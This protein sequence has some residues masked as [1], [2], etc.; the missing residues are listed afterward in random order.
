MLTPNRK[1]RFVPP[2]EAILNY[3][4]FKGGVNTLFRQTEIRPTELAQA[5]NLLLTGSGVPT[6]R[7][8]SQNYFLAAATGY[9]RGLVPVKSTSNVIELLAISDQGVIAKKNGASYTP[10]TGASWASGYN[11]EGVQLYNK[12]YFTN[13][14][15]ELVRYDF[16]TLVSFTTIATPAGTAAT[17]FSGATGVSSYGWRVAA[18]TQVGETLASTTISLASLPQQLTSTLVRISWT[19][20]SAASG[21]LTGYNIYRGAP[22]S[23]TWVGTVDQNTSRFDDFGQTGSILRQ[24]PTANTTGGPVAKFIIRFQDRLVM[25]GIPGE[26][27][28]VL[29]SGRVPNQER[30]DWSGGGGY[31]LVD[32]DTGENVTGLGVHQGRIIVFKENSVWQLSL[33][34]VTIGNF[35]VLEPVYQLITASQGCSSHRS[36]A[37]VDNDLLFCNKRGVY[38]LGYEPNITG[39]V[40][41]TNELSAKIRPFFET[42][43]DADFTS[44]TGIYFDYKYILAFPGAHKAIMF[45]KERIAWMG[46]WSTTFGIN[47]F[48]KFTDSDGVERLVCIDSDD[49]MVTEFSKALTDDKGVAFGTVLRTKRDDFGQWT[50]F[51]TINEMFMNFKNVVGTVNVNVYLEGRDGSTS[52]AKTFTITGTSQTV[53]SGWGTDLWGEPRWGVSEN[54]ANASSEDIIRRALIY[55]TARLMQIEI[56]TNNAADKYELLNIK[57]LAIPQG[58]GNV[59]STWDVE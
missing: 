1:S 19:P 24:P 3:T 11:L 41:R 35:A 57:A 15:R 18:T 2:K 51:K 44:C 13:G 8:G 27:T 42:I 49:S 58:A 32:P 9:G 34:T 39:D 46:P 29:I 10:I 54:D 55:K 7:Y 20:V 40:L 47:K 5:D 4:N 12:V 6:K 23:E 28:K 30:F 43:S 31:V 33:N 53:T 21:V 59:G 16:S 36:I 37:Y 26:P 56:L 52:V 50:L 22:G 25:A 48:A 14:Q 17:N 45:D 38:V